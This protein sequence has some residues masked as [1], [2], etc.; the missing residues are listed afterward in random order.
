VG[1]LPIT[2]TLS[3]LSEDD[4]MTI[5]T[6]PKNA[7]VKQY[8]KLFALEGVKL[9][10]TRSALRAV[11][12]EAIRRESGARGMRAIL[13]NQMLDI[14]YEV[15]FLPGVTECVVTEAVIDSGEEPILTFEKKQS[16]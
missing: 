14:M 13:E 7:L 12:Q 2:A 11:A 16:A 5:L 4:L 15:P 8:R 9:S 1:R 3:D 10:F 6:E